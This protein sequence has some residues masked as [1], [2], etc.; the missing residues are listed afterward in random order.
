MSAKINIEINKKLTSSNIK[1]MALS[2]VVP[3]L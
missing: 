1:G 2:K 3:G